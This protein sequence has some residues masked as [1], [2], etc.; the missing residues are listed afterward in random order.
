[1]TVP[2]TAKIVAKI[3]ETPDG[4]SALILHDGEGRRLPNQRNVSLKQ[5]GGELAAITVTF[6][7]CKDV[8]LA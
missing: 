7:V 3:V 2:L 5:E 8:T 4:R 6:V 1:M